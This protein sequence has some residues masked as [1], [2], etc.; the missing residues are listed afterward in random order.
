MISRFEQQDIKYL[1]GTH[2]VSVININDEYIKYYLQLHD[3]W[4]DH[5]HSSPV[6]HLVPSIFVCFKTDCKQVKY[7]ILTEKQQI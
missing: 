6:G 7:S 4:E 2:N 3:L 1:P 5:F